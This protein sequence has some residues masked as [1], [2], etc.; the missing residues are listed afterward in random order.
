[1]LVEMVYQTAIKFK[2][3]KKLLNDAFS[4]VLIIFP[5]VVNHEF[6]SN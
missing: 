1:M 6:Y 5:T 2:K 3:N 4:I